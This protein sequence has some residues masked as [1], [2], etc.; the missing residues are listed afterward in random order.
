[1]ASLGM[2]EADRVSMD[3]FK[4]DVIDVSMS[5][6]VILDFWAEWCGPCKALAPL[7]EKVVGDYTA[8]GIRLHKVNV[9][10]EKFVAAQFRIQSIPT[11][12]AVWQ[13]QIVADLT[14]M[15]SESQLRLALDQI[16]AQVQVD[17]DAAAAAGDPAAADIAQFV[18]MGEEI[19]EAGDPAR[20]AGIFAQVIEIAPDN[21]AAQIG[22]VRALAAGGEIDAAKEALNALDPTLANDP[23][24][25]QAAAQIHLADVP[26]VGHGEIAAL[27]ARLAANL[28]DFDAVLA[29]ADHDMAHGDRDSAADRL[30]AAVERDREWNG[31]AAKAKLLDLFTAIGLEDPWVAA[32]RRRLSAIL[33]G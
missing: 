5:A 30:L 17:P 6:L 24:L 16:L 11:V 21:Q 19:L 18:A 23:R 33:F 28:D 15:R 3:N 20:A 9:D 22:L 27:K 7:L 14:P 2:S 26:P 1:M 25:A 4:R 29:L 8:K 12:Y 10:E 32:Q 13:G 31:G